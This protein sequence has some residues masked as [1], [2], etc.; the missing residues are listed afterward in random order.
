M[1]TSTFLSATALLDFNHPT[2]AQLL[3]DKGWASL[4]TYD[5][6]GAVYNYVRDEIE[7][8]YNRSDAIPASEVLKDGY[9]QCNTK[10]ILLMALF[11]AVGVEA[12]LHGFTIHKALQRGVVPEI[13][14]PITPDNIVHS[15]VEISYRGRW[16]HLEGFILDSDY[17]KQLQ[18][19][20]GG[21]STGYCGYGVGTTN[22][23][24]PNVDWKGSNTYIQNTAINQDYGVFV[25]PDEFYANYGQDL[26]WWKAWLYRTLFRH[27]M[28]RRVRRIRSG[29]KP[30]SLPTSSCSPSMSS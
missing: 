15:W 24:N 2:I 13:I 28:N 23:A 21:D 11:R 16:L 5:R 27:W 3:E 10:A 12:R 25:S 30:S 1:N 9:G 14:Y 29:H 22:L 19:F 17:L 20:I 18:R 6:I 8:G 7:F 4:S 26:S